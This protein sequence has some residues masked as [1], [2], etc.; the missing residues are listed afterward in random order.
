MNHPTC[1]S[2]NVQLSNL[3]KIEGSPNTQ[4]NILFFQVNSDVLNIFSYGGK[5]SD[6]D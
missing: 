6:N 5:K 4:I 2:E 3:A 1:T